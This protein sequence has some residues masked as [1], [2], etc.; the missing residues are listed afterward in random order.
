MA[1]ASFT[2]EAALICPVVLLT[3]FA[4]FMHAFR[5]HDR[6]LERTALSRELSKMTGNASEEWTCPKVSL[7][8][9]KARICFRENEMRMERGVLRISGSIGDYEESRSLIRPEEILRKKAV[10]AET[11]PDGAEELIREEDR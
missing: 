7:P 8:T 4:L 10:F 3:I 5:L 11:D 1:S 2:V 9:L 6:V